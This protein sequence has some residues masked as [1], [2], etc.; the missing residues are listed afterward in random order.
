MNALTIVAREVP[1]PP[2]PDWETARRIRA[3]DVR[4]GRRRRAEADVAAKLR[5]ANPK[6]L[7][8]YR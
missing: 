3:G 6:Y 4:A 8:R 1:D 5:V 7:E 2:E